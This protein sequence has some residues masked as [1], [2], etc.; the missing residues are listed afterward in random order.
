M[1]CLSARNSEKRIGKRVG[2]VQ[3][4]PAR[5]GTPDSV[6]WCTRQCPVREAGPREL[7]ALGTRRRRT[8]KI[9]RT[10]RWCT[11]LSCES[12]A[13]NSTPSGKANGRRGYNS[14]DW[15]VVHRTVRWCIGLSDE[16]TVA[17]ANGR[18]R[19]FRTTRGL[20][21]RSAGAPDSVRCANQ[22]IGATVGYA[23]SGWRSHIGPSTG[24]VRWRTG[25]SGVPLD[26]SQG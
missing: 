18:P 19:N 3:Q 11:R 16:P 1:F 20:L 14:P 23:K 10:V 24:A 22:P 6:Q 4:T 12:S 9:H 2:Y 13:A 17:S 21:Q 7:A 25:Q 15:L 26:R 5:L 8:A